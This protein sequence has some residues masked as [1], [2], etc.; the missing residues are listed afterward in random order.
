MRDDLFLGLPWTLD[1]V[2]A[3][4]SRNG[5]SFYIRLALDILNLLTVSGLNLTLSIAAIYFSLRVSG[6]CNLYHFD[7][8]ADGFQETSTEVEP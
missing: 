3:A 8:Q 2:S 5:K 6:C 1:V 4:I 7:L